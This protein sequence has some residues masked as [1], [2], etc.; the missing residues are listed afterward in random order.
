MKALQVFYGFRKLTKKAIRKVEFA[1]VFE[2][3]DTRR[4]IDSINRNYHIAYTRFQSEGEKKD[5][6]NTNRM[7]TCYSYFLKDK[8]WGGCIDKVLNDNY[9]AD[10]NN[11]SKKTRGEIRKASKRL[12]LELDLDKHPDCENKNKQLE[13]F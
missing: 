7:F 3:G 9:N 1:V 2:N 8:R 5:S 6:S 4:N 10:S 11:V 12:F 13:L